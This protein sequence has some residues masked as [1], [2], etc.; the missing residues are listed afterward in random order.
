[1]RKMLALLQAFAALRELPLAP[2]RLLLSAWEVRVA[3]PGTTTCSQPPVLPEA[4]TLI[5]AKA[6]LVEEILS[7]RV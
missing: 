7:L 1:M 2:N 6:S 4:E 5:P 3:V